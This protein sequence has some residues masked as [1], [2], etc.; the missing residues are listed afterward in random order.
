MGARDEDRKLALLEKKLHAG[1]RLSSDEK[2]ELNELKRQRH[3]RNKK[4]TSI[5]SR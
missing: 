2:Q 4:R 5:Y 1:S 3:Q